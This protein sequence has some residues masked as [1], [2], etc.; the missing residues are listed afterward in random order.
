MYAA[1]RMVAAGFCP[2]GAVE[3]A[4]VACVSLEQAG[5]EELFFIFRDPLRVHRY[6]TSPYT[7]FNNMKFQHVGTALTY[8]FQ[9]EVNLF[10]GQIMSI[11]V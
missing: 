2:A 4:L 3:H 8:V 5:G 11:C 9:V 10:F 7:N 6:I 1:V